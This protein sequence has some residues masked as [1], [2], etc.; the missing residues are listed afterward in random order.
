MSQQILNVDEL[1][2]AV[3]TKKSTQEE[4]LAALAS[5]EPWLTPDVIDYLVEKISGYGKERE[6]AL[7]LL[8]QLDPAFVRRKLPDLLQPVINMCTD[9]SKKIR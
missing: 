2:Q 1:F 9:T 5:S 4:F 7:P 6:I 3:F 8:T